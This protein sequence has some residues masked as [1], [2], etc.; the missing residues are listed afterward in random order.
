MGRRFKGGA[1]ASAKIVVGGARPLLTSLLKHDRSIDVLARDIQA[2]LDAVPGDFA[3]AVREVDDARET[4]L[5]NEYASFHA[6]SMMKVPVMIELYRQAQEGSLRLDDPIRVK[7]E[8]RSSVGGGRFSLTPEEDSCEAL[9]T[10]IGEKRPIRT[11][12]REMI[13]ASSNLATNLLLETVG[14]DAVTQTMRRYGAEHIWVRR[15]VEDMRA[16]RRG[17]NNETSAHDL[18]VLFERIARGRAVSEDVS[19]E[20]IDLLKKQEHTDMIPARLPEAVEVAHK[21]GWI[22]GVRHDAG[23]VYVP[24]GPT[25]VLVFLSKGLGAGRTG[26]DACARISRRV[27]D[28]MVGGE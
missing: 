23:I 12:M 2:V 16:Y 18:L 19:H 20:M 5:F 9:Y 24:G 21:T 6:A 8:F 14:A 11:L 13:A 27:F 25:Y 22:P 26:K 7:N 15:G 17:Y 1:G 10:R 3:V 28:S 4:L